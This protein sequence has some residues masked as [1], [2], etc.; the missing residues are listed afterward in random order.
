MAIFRSRSNLAAVGLLA[1]L[2]VTL[3]CSA[4]TST[5]PV[6]PTW[7]PHAYR[8]VL[9]SAPSSWHVYRN[10]ECIPNEHPGALALGAANGPGTCE[11][12]VGP[13]GTVVKVSELSPGA[14]LTLPPPVTSSTL[15]LHGL[16]ILSNTYSTGITIWQVA[17][18]GVEVIG[19]GPSAPTVMA[20]LRPA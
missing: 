15:H 7:R 14:L 1:S 6:G 10:A 13:P 20:T 3:G 16:T 12:Q 5:S 8:A 2:I 18:A 11:D 17:S 4:T 19:R 9:I